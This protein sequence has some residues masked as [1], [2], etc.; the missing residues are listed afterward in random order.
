MLG[1]VVF[2]IG[3]SLILTGGIAVAKLVDQTMRDKARKT[4]RI[5]FPSDLDPDRVTAWLRTLSGTLRTS[6]ATRM[7][8]GLPTVVLEVWATNQGITHRL[9][10]PWQ[11]EPM[12]RPKLESLVPGVRMILEEEHPVRVWVHAVEAGLKASSRQLRIPNAS[13]LSTNILSNFG[14]LGDG[15][16][17]MMQWVI[18]PAVPEHKPVHKQAETREL[19]IATLFHGV[20]ATKDEVD[21]RRGKLD[22]PNMLAVL[23]VAAVASTP[24]RAQFMVRGVMA[25]LD[26]SRGPSTRFYRR[27]TTK[28]GLQQHIDMA[29]APLQFAVQLSVSELTAVLGW[30]LGNPMVPGLPSGVSRYLPSPASVPTKGRVLGQSNYPGRERTVAAP[31]PETMMHTWIVGASGMGKSNLMAGMAKQDME[32]DYG[33]VAI[34]SKGDLFPR[35]LDYVPPRRINDV[36]VMDLTDT[37]FPVGFN[38][39]QQGHPS[40][41]AAELTGVFERFFGTG[42]RSLWMH[43]LM[44]FAIPTLMLDPKST[45]MDLPALVSPNADE[46][47]WSDDLIRKVTDPY[48]SAYWQRATNQGQTR[49]DLKADPLLSRFHPL[50][51]P[52][53]RNILGQSQSTFYMDDVVKNNKIL[54]VNLAGVDKTSASIMGTLIMNCLWNSVQ[55]N[56]SQKGIHLYL[57]EFQRFIDI[58]VDT[59]S[60]FAEARSMG[61]GM[62]LAHQQLTQIKDEGLKQSLFTNAG[63]KLLFKISSDDARKL[64]NEMGPGVTDDDLT[65]MAKREVFARVMTSEGVSSPFT[66]TTLDAAKGYGKENQVR[67]VSRQQFGRPVAQVQDEMLGRR[68]AQEPPEREPPPAKPGWG[69]LG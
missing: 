1:F 66:F 10:V 57:D 68:G 41:I 27:M 60:M 25:S 51:D 61:L 31:Y 65:N 11:Y 17:L 53:I 48:T 39:L 56:R 63:T 47:A 12:I 20:Q 69:A 32:N 36:I 13:D 64:A 62:V 3:T 45:I 4:Y 29:R 16:T 52:A 46:R 28:S 35:L 67:Y 38:L 19:S 26:S 43:E 14:T 33:L 15:E 24:I 2:I 34:E 42:G 7:F 5:A 22:E 30:P 55:R 21:D 50:T 49:Q 8:Q 59:E 23:R 9:K 18:S 37:K 6:G 40:V 58:P 54:L 44:K